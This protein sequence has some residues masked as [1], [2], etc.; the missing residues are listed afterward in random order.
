MGSLGF[1]EFG[2]AGVWD[3]RR[4]YFLSYGIQE[5]ECSCFET[6]GSGW[7]VSSTV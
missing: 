7:F 3:L 6:S 4:E 1:C 5:I 2:C